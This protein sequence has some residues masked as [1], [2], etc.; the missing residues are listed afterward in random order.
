M[1]NWQISLFHTTESLLSRSRV[2]SESLRLF[3]EYVENRSNSAF[4]YSFRGCQ[5]DRHSSV[6]LSVNVIKTCKNSIDSLGTGMDL[7]QLLNDPENFF[8]S[9]INKI[10]NKIPYIRLI[11]FI[12]YSFIK[13]NS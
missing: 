9:L 6:K 5:N 13:S 2:V 11:A 3:L 12:K 4:P 8:T 1:P 10:Y 7:I